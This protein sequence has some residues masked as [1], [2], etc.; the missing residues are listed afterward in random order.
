MSIYHLNRQDDNTNFSMNLTLNHFLILPKISLLEPL[1]IHEK[2]Y[3]FSLN[4]FLFKIISHVVLIGLKLI[5]YVRQASGSQQSCWSFLRT[6][7]R[8]YQA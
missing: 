6:F 8:R 5:M 3:N 1:K 2:R 7:S 4:I